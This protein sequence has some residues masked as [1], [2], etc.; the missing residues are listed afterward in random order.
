MDFL[1]ALPQG[2]YRQLGVVLRA[3]I[4]GER[5]KNLLL[6]LKEAGLVWATAAGAASGRSR[7]SG[8]TEPLVWGYF[9]LYRSPRRVYVREVTVREDFWTLR[10]NPGKLRAALEI[11]ADAARFSLPGHP[12]AEVLPILYWTLKALEA[13]TEP[14]AVRLRF[15]YRWGMALGIVPGLDRCSACGKPFT[16]GFLTLQGLLCTACAGP[17]P[18]TACL[19]LGEKELNRLKKAV[20]LSGKDFRN[21]SFCRDELPLFGK[22]ST[23]LTRLIENSV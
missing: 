8:V 18:A 20:M 16:Q 15:L 13:G 1:P 17:S 6:L 11:C 5:A 4:S 21:E 12:P 14:A 22:V 7:L 2:H 10:Q 3:A 9:T 23:L 19:P